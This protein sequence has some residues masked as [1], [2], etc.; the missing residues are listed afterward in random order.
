MSRRLIS[1]ASKPCR[2]GSTHATRPRR[3]SS[4]H[5]AV[6]SFQYGRAQNAE[7]APEI[8]GPLR[9]VGVVQQ[10]PEL[11][12]DPRVDSGGTW[13]TS[14]QPPARVHWTPAPGEEQGVTIGHEDAHVS[15]VGPHRL[16]DVTD[17][18]PA[19]LRDQHLLG[20]LAVS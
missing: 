8:S 11:G 15:V 6:G 13:H 7:A 10:Q 1:R 4:R 19:V 14:R 20:L 2:T 18:G 9:P 5:A 17:L 12:T 16:A 3:P